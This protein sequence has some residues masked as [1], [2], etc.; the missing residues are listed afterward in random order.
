M[1]NR[2]VAMGTQTGNLSMAVADLV[3][4]GARSMLAKHN[5]ETA[6]C[7]QRELTEQLGEHFKMQ[8][9]W[10]IIHGG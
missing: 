5:C 4:A 9:F 8:A 6:V 3:N 7:L 10:M 1:R 2:Q